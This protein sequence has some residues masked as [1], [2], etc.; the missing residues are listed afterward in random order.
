V[1]RVLITGGAGFLGS[2]LAER[3]RGEHEVMVLDNIWALH[4]HRHANI[5]MNFLKMVDNFFD[6]DAIL[7]HKRDLQI[8]DEQNYG[9][10]WCPWLL[11]NDYPVWL[12][13]LLRCDHPKHQP[14]WRPPVHDH[15]IPLTTTEVVEGKLVYR[16]EKNGVGPARN[17]KDGFHEHYDGPLR[18]YMDRHPEVSES[19][20]NA[21]NYHWDF[22]AKQG[23]HDDVRYGCPDIDTLYQY[24]TPG[25]MA[26]L[27]KH[28]Y[29]I[30]CY[31]I[32]G[33]IDICPKKLQFMYS[34]TEA[35]VFERIADKVA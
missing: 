35:K 17:S 30:V 18:R 29:E 28:G 26:H 15:P 34:A 13:H 32:T 21:E 8:Y 14:Y 2:H 12:P 6:G 3:L 27:L 5:D 33:R 22:F 10:Q 19:L 24:W 4:G 11:M 23:R 9:P 20:T 16:I 1:S 25:F 31:E 7:H